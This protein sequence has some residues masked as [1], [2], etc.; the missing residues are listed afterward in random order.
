[1]HSLLIPVSGCIASAHQRSNES[2]N[3]IKVITG[4]LHKNLVR[5]RAK[6]GSFESQLVRFKFLCW[7]SF[8][9]IFWSRTFKSRLSYEKDDIQ[10][11]QIAK[12]IKYHH[13]W[14]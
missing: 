11:F 9:C 6:I 1:M 13:R 5:T 3:T 8:I 2:K 10:P 14:R 12:E 7:H 4:G